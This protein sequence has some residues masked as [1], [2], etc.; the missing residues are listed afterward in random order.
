MRH[1][2]ATAK[3][4][5][6]MNIEELKEEVLRAFILSQSIEPLA[7]KPGCTTRTVDSSPG[8]KLEYFIISA[9]NSA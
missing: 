5:H 2:K 3:G 7:E 6:Q 9:V 1:L 8:T 4:A